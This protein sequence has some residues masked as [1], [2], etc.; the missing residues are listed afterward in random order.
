[1]SHSIVRH[2]G[3][4]CVVEFMQGNQPVLGFV[5]EEQS[6][7]L[8]VLTRNKR[9]TKLPVAR[10]LPWAGPSFAP[11]QSRTEIE[12]LL[13]ACQKRR[14]ELFESIDPIELWEMVQGEVDK[15]RPL[16]FA[17]LLWQE[18]DADQLAAMGRALLVCKTHFKFRPP[19]FEILPQEKVEA[20]MIEQEKARERERLIGV[21]KHFIKA[22]WNN[23]TPEAI[24]DAAAEGLKSLLMRK[25]ADPD[26][27]ETEMVWREIRRG[28][29]EDPHLPLLVAQRWGIIPDHYNYLLD[30]AGYAW[31]DEWAREFDAE[32]QAQ[33]H[34]VSALKAESEPENGFVSVD[35][36]STRDIDDAFTI[37]KDGDG[38]RL[39]LALACPA[40]GWNFESELHRAVADRGTSIYLPEGAAYMIPEKLATD[41]CSLTEG[42][43]RP[44][45]IAEFAI[46]PD[47]EVVASD[48]RFGTA[49][50]KRNATYVDTEAAIEA[51]IDTDMVEA[52]NLA[53][54]LR[55]RRIRN[56][57]VII[58]REDPQI[59][60]EP[61]YP[62][63][64]PIKV[65]LDIK[66]STP[67]AQLV[68]SEFMILSNEQSA[69]WAIENDIPLMFRTQDIAL[70]QK[71]AGVWSTPQDI[72]RIVK[73]FGA[74]ILETTPKPHRGLGIKAYASI[75]SP[76]RRYPDFVNSEQFRHYL[77][78]GEPRWTKDEL[79]ATLPRLSARL[80]LAGKVQRF[81]PR[82]WKLLY[83]KQNPK[84][85][86]EGI[87]VD[88]M[89]NLVQLALPEAQIF[90]RA[91]RKMLG[92]K[93][94]PGQSFMLRLNKVDP[95]T[96]EIRVVEALEN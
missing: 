29:P 7:R 2:P 86:V 84:K 50:I 49:V 69:L 82:Y 59:T 30:Q 27:T 75:T 15:G 72:C 61:N 83:F 85:L 13:A 54:V 95:L 64:E 57:A 45:I 23:A 16:F 47:G 88:E 25:I 39:T 71:F 87:V 8:K 24:E 41:T 74:T 9:E 10:T 26:D 38:W 90:V 52:W 89:G 73:H 63:D 80:E 5:L 22:L 53:Q 62:S 43:M 44:A 79:Q 60:L 55:E 12:Q 6:G 67:K 32:I 46:A 21:G 31:D 40:A 28:L 91:P 3:A 48:F 93:I 4:G 34:F 66:E 96:N 11:D 35:S 37:A 33:E 36:A 65:T 76:L 17:E 51:E 18:P 81:R 68:V 56:H 14:Q 92:D 77:T 94:Y 58:D 1:M 70:P 78:T 42:N 19:E 20:R